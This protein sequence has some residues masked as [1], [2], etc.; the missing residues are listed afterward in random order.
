MR[1]RAGPRYTSAERTR[2]GERNRIETL[3]CG[4]AEVERVVMRGSRRT[5]AS[6][7]WTYRVSCRVRGAPTRGNRACRYFRPCDPN[8]QP[9]VGYMTP[10][11]TLTTL[12]LL[13]NGHISAGLIE[14]RS[15]ECAAIHHGYDVRLR[16][17]A[18]THD[19]QSASNTVLNPVI[20]SV[21]LPYSAVPMRI[22]S[23]PCVAL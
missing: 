4:V 8:P 2:R 11:S 23:E 10:P 13:V 6:G 15:Q 14:A 9:K 5:V 1:I 7:T 3:A 21:A 16:C 22:H 20:A 12:K 19:Q 17:V 18:R